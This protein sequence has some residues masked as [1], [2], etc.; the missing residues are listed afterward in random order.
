[1]TNK[2]KIYLDSCCFIDLATYRS[3]ITVDPERNN[4]VW[5]CKRLIEA[6][7]NKDIEVYVST[8]SVTECL[9]I[10]DA[11]QRKI[12]NEEIKRL[13]SSVL[14]SGK[15]GVI[16]VQPEYN[17]IKRARDLFWIDGID[18]KP[19]DSIH[20]A[21]ALEIGCNE[22]ITTDKHTYENKV[23]QI[24]RLGLTVLFSASQTRCLP[25]K[26]RQQTIGESETSY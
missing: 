26:Y 17:I 8:I 2:P 12:L 7:Q 9:Y 6:S 19:L 20:L 23:A 24:A 18:L 13:F 21:S 14:L 3:G 15:S 10:R 5:Y 16:P 11:E 25:D 1:M 4:H 22:F